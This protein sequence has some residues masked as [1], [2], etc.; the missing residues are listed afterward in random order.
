MLDTK[1]TINY[2]DRNEALTASGRILFVSNCLGPWS[3]II[4]E[5]FFAIISRARILSHQFPFTTV[6]T[7]QTHV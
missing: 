6:A 5:F 4:I 7:R 1:I 2:G 3:L